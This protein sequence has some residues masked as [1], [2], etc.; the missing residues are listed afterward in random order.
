MSDE[1]SRFPSDPDTQPPTPAAAPPL[2]FAV[3]DGHGAPSEA[4]P[5]KAKVGTYVDDQAVEH[6]VEIVAERKDGSVD[7]MLPQAVGGYR[8]DGVRRRES[9]AQKGDYLK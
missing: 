6:Q 1:A 9:E 2:P 3:F 5:T 7:I 4:V 8:R